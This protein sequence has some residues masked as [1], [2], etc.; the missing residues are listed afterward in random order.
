MLVGVADFTWA[1]P[2][3]DNGWEQ[4]GAI[5]PA[6]LAAHHQVDWRAMAAKALST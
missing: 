3:G 1:A 6:G 5:G 2:G 4:Y